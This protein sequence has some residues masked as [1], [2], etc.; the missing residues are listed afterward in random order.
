MYL[1][2][3]LCFQVIY[4]TNS[5]GEICGRGQHAMR[6]YLLFFDLTRCLNPAVMSLGCP[7]MQVCVK[8]CPKDKYSGYGDAMTALA[9]F[10]GELT[11]LGER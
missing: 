4:P 3:C 9:P 11:F 1:S 8:E 10:Q 7:T 6:P 5:K 2:L